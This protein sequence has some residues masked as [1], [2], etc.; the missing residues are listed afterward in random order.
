MIY[1]IQVIE[2][3][4]INY[5]WQHNIQLLLLPCTEVIH[6]Q[7]QI[8]NFLEKRNWSNEE[9]ASVSIG[10]WLGKL[11]DVKKRDKKIYIVNK[12]RNRRSQK[13]EYLCV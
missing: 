4:F 8:L 13:G 6:I 5:P 3:K 12:G 1:P 9:L 10:F 2:L 7:W 11:Y